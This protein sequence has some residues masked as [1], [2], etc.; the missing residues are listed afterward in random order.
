MI[1]SDD[2]QSRQ[3]KIIKCTIYEY[4]HRWNRS[5]SYYIEPCLRSLSI[6]WISHNSLAVVED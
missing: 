1:A 4:L 5:Q 2:V 3:M 6:L